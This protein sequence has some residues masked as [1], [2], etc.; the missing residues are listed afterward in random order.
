MDA[1]RSGA[2][3]SITRHK[4]LG[5]Q[6]FKPLPNPTGLFPYHTRLQDIISLD[7][8]KKLTMQEKL[9]FMLQEILEE[10]SILY[11]NRL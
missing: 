10:S 6:K 9:Y 7:N 8:I 1:Q 5:N 3:Q 2:I 11:H 4:A